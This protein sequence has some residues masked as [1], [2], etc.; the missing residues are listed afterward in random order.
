MHP[1]AAFLSAILIVLT[2]TACGRR[3]DDSLR[4]EDTSPP[5]TAAARTYTQAELGA[6]YR[7]GNAGDICREDAQCDPPLRCVHGEC[8]FP[9]AMTGRAADDTPSIHVGEGEDARVIHL[10]IA[11]TPPEQARGLMYR[12]HMH[13]A[14]GMLF[15]F[16][17]DAPRAFWMK[18]T[19]ISLD[20]IFIRS[21]GV[22]DSVL[23]HVP[24]HTLESRESDG[25]ARYVLELVAGEAQRLGVEAGTTLRFE[26]LGRDEAP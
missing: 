17:N 11:R 21:D 1:R 13:P 16:E 25:P 18:N 3:D 6:L 7:A 23:A 24:P 12:E 9:L 20:M 2:L 26:G 10:E 14:L 19:L 4:A 8:L 5:P 22:V 15:I